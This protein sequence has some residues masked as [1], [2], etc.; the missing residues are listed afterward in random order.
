M[1]QKTLELDLPEPV[2]QRFEKQPPQVRQVAIQLAIEAIEAYLE[3]E[4]R[5]EAG[6]EMLRRLPEKAKKYKGTGPSDLA[7]RHDDYIYGRD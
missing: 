6:R 3:R 4:A 7:S 2:Y 1:G 5:L